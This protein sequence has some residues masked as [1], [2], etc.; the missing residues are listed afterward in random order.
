MIGTCIDVLA[1]ALGIPIETGTLQA[2]V[3]YAE[4]VQTWNVRLNLTAA[5]T[6]EALVEVLFGDAFVM[7]DPHFVPEGASLLDVGSGA[8]APAIG[9]ALLR[10]DVRVTLVDPQHKRVAFLNTAIGSLGLAGRVRAL[11]GRVDPRRPRIP[12][13]QVFDVASAR[14][15]FPP[16]AWARIGLAL[17][18]ACLVY[19]RDEI[20]VPI[21]ARLVHCAQYVL[22]WSGAPRAL[23]RIERDGSTD[24]E[25][26]GGR[27]TK[28]GTQ[29]GSTTPPTD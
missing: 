27:S 10:P 28:K 7:R 15:T 24:D 16:Q 3:R 13:E 17:A 18:P 14:A 1:R 25:D 4:L 22:P 5:L 12:S 26:Q 11:S 29:G 20:P 2:L 8:G 9:F 19:G 23:G 21:G 6:E